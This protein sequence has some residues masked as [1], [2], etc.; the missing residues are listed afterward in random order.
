MT[1]VNPHIDVNA[2]HTEPEAKKSSRASSMNR[3]FGRNRHQSAASVQEDNDSGSTVSDKGLQPLTDKEREHLEFTRNNPLGRMLLNMHSDACDMTEKT[4]LK[5]LSQNMRDLCEG[6]YTHLQLERKLIKDEVKETAGELEKNMLSREINSHWLNQD[7]KPPT[8]F[9]VTPTL[10]TPGQRA[11]CL[12]VFPTRGQKFSGTGDNSPNVIEFLGN[13]RAAQEICKLSEK[14]FFDMVLACTTGPAHMLIMD[15]K[16]QGNTVEGLYNNLIMYY[17]K[18]ITPEDARMQLQN[19]K[20]EKSSNLSKVEGKIMSLSTRASSGLPP[21]P[22]QIMQFNHEAIMALV[23]ALPFEASN[24]VQNNY[25]ILSAKLGRT[26]TFGELTSALNLYRRQIDLDIRNNGVEGNYRS[27]GNNWKGKKPWKKQKNATSYAGNVQD[28]EGNKGKGKWSGKGEQGKMGNGKNWKGNGNRG[29]NKGQGRN[30]RPAQDNLSYCSLCGKGDHKAADGC[31]FMQ[32]DNGK[33]ILTMPTH[34]TCRS[35]PP[36]VNPRLN[37]PYQ[38][39]P[40][41]AGGPLHGSA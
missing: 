31:M 17:D 1:E 15:W 5:E 38:I 14:E 40:F 24:I 19:F 37:H 32:A 18:R 33:Q 34:T 30:F 35:C 23:R 25:Q 29:Q 16:A 39:C 36:S 2:I 4:G 22:A 41:R 7:F 20:A 6:F 8:V 27:G 28:G 11:E 12:R 10:L 3:L 9:S 26:C 13:M 21:G